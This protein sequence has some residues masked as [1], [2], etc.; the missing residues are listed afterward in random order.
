MPLDRVAFAYARKH[1]TTLEEVLR[2]S[3]DIIA[4]SE[5]DD[6]SLTSPPAP[7]ETVA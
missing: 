6:D 3:A 2:V 7:P 5:P 1:V 4:T